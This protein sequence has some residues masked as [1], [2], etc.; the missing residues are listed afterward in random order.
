MI[1]VIPVREDATAAR[2]L[3]SGDVRMTAPVHVKEIA[4]GHAKEIV[5]ANVPHPVTDKIWM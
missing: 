1:A 2:E 3:V 5:T 4:N